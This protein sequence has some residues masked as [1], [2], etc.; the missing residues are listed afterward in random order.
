MK[1]LPIFQVEMTERLSRRLKKIEAREKMDK[2]KATIATVAKIAE[3]H[4]NTVRNRPWVKSRLRVIKSKRRKLTDQS[5]D[6]KH[7]TKVTI[8]DMLR[9]RIRS[10]L[11][12]NAMLYQETIGAHAEIKKKN[13]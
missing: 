10:L 1:N 9:A 7:L 8:E 4:P 3:V 6:D 2:L 13:K 5:N 12:Q 11:E